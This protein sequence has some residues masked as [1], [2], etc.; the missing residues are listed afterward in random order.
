MRKAGFTLVEIMIVVL[1]ISVLLGVAVPSFL[2]SRKNS[3]EIA[4]FANQDKLDDAK[5]LWYQ[6][7]SAALTES[8]L[9]SDL[10][11]VY[12][13]FIP[14]CPANGAYKLGDAATDVTCSEHPR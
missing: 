8:P 1:I 2:S 5:A 9:M 14:K 6:E 13:R 4:C 12:I 3:R 7:T 11:P 10:V